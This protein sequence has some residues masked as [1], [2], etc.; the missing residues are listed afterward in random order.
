MRPRPAD[1]TSRYSLIDPG[2]HARTLSTIRFEWGWPT[3]LVALATLLPFIAFSTGPALGQS[4]SLIL[5][6]VPGSAAAFSVDRLRSGYTSPVVIIRRA[7]DDSTL[8]VGTIGDTFDSLLFGDFVANSAAYVSTFYDQSGNASDAS[9]SVALRQ[10]QL[11]PGP[12]GAYMMALDGR[13]GL[14]VP[15]LYDRISGAGALTVFVVAS[16]DGTPSNEAIHLLTAGRYLPAGGRYPLGIYLDRANG[17]YAAPWAAVNLSDGSRITLGSPAVFG[18]ADEL[19]IY[20]LVFDKDSG[21]ALYNSGRAVDDVALQGKSL[22]STDRYKEG[23]FLGANGDFDY[24]L[25]GRMAPPLV[26]DRALSGPERESV[27]HWLAQEYGV[28]IPHR[29][30]PTSDEFTIAFI[31]DTQEYAAGLSGATP[32]LIHEAMDWIVDNQVPWNIQL[33]LH[34]GDVVNR[35]N[36]IREWMTA[37][38]WFSKV[39]EARLPHAV[40]VGNHDYLYPLS[41]RVSDNFNMLF[42]AADFEK[43]Q[44]WRDGGFFEPG[45]S[46]NLYFV[47][48][49]GGEDYLILTMEFQ[50]RAAVVN[51][52]D[53][54]LRDHPLHKAIV[55]THEFTDENGRFDNVTPGF[56]D[57][58]DSQT[59]YDDLISQH[60]NIF[61]VLSGHHARGTSRRLDRG[62]GAHYLFF[63]PMLSGWGRKGLIRLLVIS[64]DRGTVRVM[65]YA[66][67]RDDYRDDF[68]NLF[69]LDVPSSA[70]PIHV[71]EGS[72]ED[73]QPGTYVLRPNYP[74]PF[75]PVTKIAYELP[76]SVFVT[77]RVYDVVGREIRTLVSQRQSAG[78]YS[79]DLDAG[80]LP[81]G[82][83]IYR[84]RAGEFEAA[85]SLTVLK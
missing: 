13:G 67:R 55:L 74:N 70:T 41:D 78:T 27:R 40:A 34:P 39:R 2:I 11:V 52:A 53:A 49:M 1:G 38:A 9:Q 4:E 76:E 18:R 72:T 81:S 30:P 48:E 12:N 10:P 43:A 65:T 7:S 23:V 16:W 85:R 6:E 29:Y 32:D 8:S 37:D 59:L 50:P 20:E 46:D 51:W 19:E 84:L 26:F 42:P 58:V 22:L 77:L 54:V 83:Y 80:N 33:V 3:S 62:T 5:D 66:P 57:A 45:K 69:T 63:D 75:N 79:V 17:G 71:E 44:W 35:P 60:H 56:T 24:G 21:I 36:E 61:L 64:P 68:Y 14:G 82:V 73:E 25:T 47:L 15:G 31:P 28:A